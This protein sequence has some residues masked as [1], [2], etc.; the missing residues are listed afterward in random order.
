[1]SAAILN[2]LG[3]ITSF[4]GRAGRAEFWL[5]VGGAF[6][7]MM[8]AF[9]TEFRW[10]FWTTH[11]YVRETVRTSLVT[12]E[13]H[14]YSEYVVETYLTL[15]EADAS[16]LTIVPLSVCAVPLAAVLVRRLHDLGRPAW[17]GAVAIYLAFGLEPTLR[18]LIT[19]FVNVAPMIAIIASLL[20]GFL[21]FILSISALIVLGLWTANEGDPEPNQFGPVP[22]GPFS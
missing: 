16:W 10:V 21:T 5:V 14:R 9:L 4:Q 20:L 19:A 18:L 8:P 3:R 2:G 1:M 15:W 22:E 6:V 12:G 13:T 7:A 17:W 11:D